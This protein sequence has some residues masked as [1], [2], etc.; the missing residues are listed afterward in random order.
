MIKPI[1]VQMKR[2]RDS[3]KEQAQWTKGLETLIDKISTTQDTGLQKLIETLE[4][5]WIKEKTGTGTRPLNMASDKATRGSSW[6]KNA[7]LDTF[8]RQLEIWKIINVDVPESTQF[9]DLVESLKMNKEINGLE[10]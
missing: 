10:K 6:T 5:K 2:M 4:K 9:Q 1:V 3:E 8:I 7:S